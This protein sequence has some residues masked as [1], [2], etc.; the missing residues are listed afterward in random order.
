MASMFKENW[1]KVRITNRLHVYMLLIVEKEIRGG[2]YH[3]IHRCAKANN[4]YTKHCDENEE[5]LFLEYLDA[6]NMYGWAMPE[7]L[8]VNGF[9]WMEVLSKIGEDFIKTMMK[10]V[11]KDIYLI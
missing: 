2:I 1:S 7:P 5:S 9:D 6:N 10:I 8:P 4:K 11:I 3:A